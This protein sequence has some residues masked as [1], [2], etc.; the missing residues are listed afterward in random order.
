MEVTDLQVYSDI[1]SS[2]HI[3]PLSQKVF[4][5]GKEKNFFSVSQMS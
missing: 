5:Q 1:L 4:V 3:T 2:L